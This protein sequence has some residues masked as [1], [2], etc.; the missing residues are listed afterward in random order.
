MKL[1]ANVD[2]DG[3]I[4]DFT[5]AMRDAFDYRRANKGG[6]TEQTPA[7]WPTPTQW[8]VWEQ[9][10]ITKTEF[11]KVLYAEILDGY[12]FRLGHR[13]DGAVEG[14]V[15]LKQLGYVVR[16]VTAKTFHDERVTRKARANTLRF[17][18]DHEIPFDEIVFSGPRGKLDFRADLVVYDMP[19][20]E[21]WAQPSALNVIFHQPWNQVI[22]EFPEG[23]DV[24][25]AFSWNDVAQLA[26]ARINQ[27]VLL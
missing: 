4:Y 9:W 26:E 2:F 25:R 19:K 15:R 22:P 23:I 21:Q 27:G 10:P 11:Y 8:S 17:L 18:S 12:A 13:I 5:T 1:V 3:V 14:M 6:P 24:A 20:L 7:Q 16:I